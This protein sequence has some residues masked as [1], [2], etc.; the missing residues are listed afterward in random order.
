M[1]VPGASQVSDDTSQELAALLDAGTLEQRENDV[2]INRVQA[3]VL[4]FFAFTWIGLL[5]ILAAA[6][7]VYDRTLK[8]SGG[9]R[10]LGEFVFL[11]ALSAFLAL[12]GIGVVRRWRWTFWLI[13]VAFLAGALRVPASILEIAGVVSATEPTWYALFQ[14]VLGFIQFA[15]GLV[16]LAGYRQAGVWGDV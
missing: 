7:D 10:R 11:L 8:L 1:V 3:L 9:H 15:I 13:L 2:V 4:G 14:G 5:V 16:M 6:P 12:L